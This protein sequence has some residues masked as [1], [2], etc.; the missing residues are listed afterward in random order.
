MVGWHFRLLSRIV[1]E[2]ILHLSKIIFYPLQTAIRT[3]N[4]SSIRFRSLQLS[5]PCHRIFKSKLNKQ[6]NTFGFWFFIRNKLNIFIILSY[7]AEFNRIFR[8]LAFSQSD[9]AFGPV[10]QHGFIISGE[11][12]HKGAVGV[13]GRVR[14]TH[15]VNRAVFKR[16][17]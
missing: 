14:F 10:D 11:L 17:S 3:M 5:V 7:G 15:V 4:I 2:G 13:L 6:L 16:K 9:N 8:F 12:G 1:K